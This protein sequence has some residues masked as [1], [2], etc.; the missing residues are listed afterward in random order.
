MGWI[1]GRQLFK[2]QAMKDAPPLKPRIVGKKK[3][4]KMRKEERE[5]EERM[6]EER[7]KKISLSLVFRVEL[8]SS[9]AKT[10][11]SVHEFGR[12]RYKRTVK[13]KWEEV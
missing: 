10:G 2:K 3:K 5:R 7:G 9:T 1:D 12:R 13:N 8:P 11:Q 6:R 4:R